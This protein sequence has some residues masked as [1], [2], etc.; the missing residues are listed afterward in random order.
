MKIIKNKSPLAEQTQAYIKL[1]ILAACACIVLKLSAWYFTGSVGLFSDAVESCVNLG[2]AV[3][4]LLM[5]R[6]AYEPADEMH[7]FGHTKAEYF[8]SAFEGSMIFIAAILIIYAAIPRLAN[9][10]PLT[11]IGVGLWFSVAATALNFVVAVILGRAAKRLNSIALRADSRHLMTDVWTTGGV[12]AGLIAVLLT[13]WLWLDALIAIGV[14]LH[15]LFE[16]YTLL[17]DSVNGLMDEALPADEIEKIETILKS[18]ESSGIYYANL[19]TRQS[20]SKRF[21][22][23]DILMPDHWDI[24][25]AHELLDEIEQKISDALG[26]TSVTTHLEPLSLRKD[27]LP[28]SSK[29]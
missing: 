11:S 21:V 3:F 12:V 5:L 2:S 27:T 14:A 25:H 17:K 13:Q 9:P 6:K 24:S 20:A 22:L 7:P 26:R 28:I 8:S 23:V 18:Y 10:Q 16:G 15:I 19:K 1:S 4:A 29:T